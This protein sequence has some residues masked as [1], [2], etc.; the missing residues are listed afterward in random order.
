MFRVPG[1]TF[2]QYAYPYMGTRIP[3]Y[4]GIFRDPIWKIYPQ[5]E[6]TGKNLLDAVF[7]STPPFLFLLLTPRTK[8]KM[9]LV[10]HLTGHRLYSYMSNIVSSYSVP[11]DRHKSFTCLPAATFAHTSTV[12]M[13]TT[14]KSWT[15]RCVTWPLH[16]IIARDHCTWLLH[17]VTIARGHCT[18]PL[19]RPLPATSPN[20]R[21]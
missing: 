6:M 17:H 4:P 3:V 2:L 19:P 11:T 18:W 7:W 9:W 10:T 13:N 1:Y 21:F 12:H 15:L 8:V 14:N 16:V 5:L 20:C